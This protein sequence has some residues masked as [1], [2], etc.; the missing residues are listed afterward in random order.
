LEAANE[1]L[2]RDQAEAVRVA[3]V[4]VTRARDLLVAPVCGD[5]P[6]EGWL[7]VLKPV[8]YPPEDSRRNSDR[9]DGCP[10]FGEDSVLDRGAEG[11]PPVAGSV[12]PGLHVPARDGSNVVW[13]DPSALALEVDENAALRHQ[14]ILEVDPHKGAAAESEKV[15]AAWKKGRTDL[16]SR[17]SQASISVQT[18]T[19]VAR[20]EA[21]QQL[22]A[23]SS[24]QVERIERGDFERASGR[25]FGALVH[26]ILASVDLDADEAAIQASAAV[27]GRLVGATEEEMI[28]AG[29]AVRATLEHPILRR[30]AVSARKGEIRRETPALLTLDGGS[31]IEGVVDLAFR[32][33]TD[34][35]SG[36][37]VVDFKTDRQFGAASDQYSAQLC[38]YAEAVHRATGL[39]SRGILLVV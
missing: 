37:T 27:N 32:E 16:L 2:R 19:A 13:W 38:M 12:R 5:E 21:S 25:R 7:D 35:F 26:A 24:V 29:A 23:R 28:A 1:E 14:R 3:Y 22:V 31:L 36:W 30:A 33:D 4:A 11:M 9:A 8:L 17:A 15:Y 39:N 20:S 10:P 6:I 18:V 34:E